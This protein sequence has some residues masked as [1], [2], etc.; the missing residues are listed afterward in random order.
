MGGR[1]QRAETGAGFGGWPDLD[2]A[3]TFTA[4]WEASADAMA[5]SD[6]EGIVLAAN[7]AYC[8]LYGYAPEEIIGRSFTLVYPEAERAEAEARYRAIFERGQADAAGYERIVRRKDGVEL[9][10]ESRVSFLRRHGRPVAMIVVIRDVTDRRRAEAALRNSEVRFARVFEISPILLTISSLATGRFLDVSESVLQTSGYT[11]EE[12]LGRTAV[13]LGLWVDEDLR[14]RGAAELAAGRR[15]LNWEARFRTKPGVIRVGL[16]SAAVA[17]FDG[18]PC[19]LTVVVDVTERKQAEEE[20]ERVLRREQAARAELEAAQRRLRFLAEAS[21]TLASSLEYDTTMANVSRLAVPELGDWCVLDAL[22]EGQY[23]R[24][25]VVHRD[26]AK[27]DIA[28]AMRRQFPPDLTAPSGVGLILR[29]GQAALYADVD[30][31]TGRSI[32]RGHPVL[33]DY[34]RRL[35]IASAMVVPLRAGDQTLG[36]LTVVSADPNRRYQQADLVLAEELA[37]RAALAVEHAR[38]YRAAQEAI[39]ARDEF[40]SIAAHELRTPVAGLNGYAQRLARA[41]DRGTLDTTQLTRSLGLMTRAGRRL[42]S[43]TEELLDV[44]RIRLGRLPLDLETFDLAM[45]VRTL[46]ERGREQLDERHRLVL[47]VPDEPRAVT[48][49]AGRIEQVLVNL[50]DN[51]GK[52]SPDGGTIAVA[53]RS[54]GGGCLVTVRDEGIGLPP[55]AAETIFQPFGR[56]PN[57]VARHLPG[58]GLGLYICRG[59]VERHGGRIWAESAGDGGGTTFC[60]WLPCRPTTAAL[61]GRYAG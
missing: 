34:V 20:R 54:E 23:R 11:R 22:E 27:A 47:D 29:T 49:D 48:A 26:P 10:G 3:A 43:L 53:L 42:A 25:A 30:E 58:M 33:Y 60:L 14:V 37:H 40:L 7:P 46:A 55:G 16:V 17:E 57:A 36:A 9:V 44:S 35:G 52:Y 59:I 18:Q 24:L 6:A 45:L 8:R 13:E 28:D 32:A 12:F 50:L 31:A 21:K 39:R 5:L 1:A 61:G 2:V 51:A 56:A 19:A 4:V 15:I 38:L 41:L